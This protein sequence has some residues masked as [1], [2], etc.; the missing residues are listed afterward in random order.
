MSSVH[1]TYAPI[2]RHSR[3]AGREGIFWQPV[4]PRDR[5]R[6]MLA[7]ERFERTRRER[8]K[9]N[10]PLGP[11]GLEVLRE[12]LRIVDFKSG[13]LEPAIVTLMQ[14][15]KRSKDAIVR[16][17]ANLRTSGFLD[18]LRR[19]RQADDGTPRQTTNA[20][21]LVLPPAAV[22]LLGHVASDIV[23]DDVAQARADREATY[24]DMMAGLSVDDRTEER[25]A[26]QSEL[27]AAAL[28]LNNARKTG[29]GS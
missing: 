16:A 28:R 10:G 15:L 18:W 4:N 29:G 8:G 14:R 26:H 24:E 1:R 27:A 2:R 17:L 3:E 25:L 21:R 5:S 7:A 11:V 12:L 6:F 20:Y 9:R 19:W 13:R 23:P 22:R